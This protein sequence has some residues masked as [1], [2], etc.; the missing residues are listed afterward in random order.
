MI[1]TEKIASAKVL[2]SLYPVAGRLARD[3][4]SR[5]EINCDGEGVLFIEAETGSAM[6]DLICWF[7]AQRRT[8]TAYSYR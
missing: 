3:A 1:D 4:N 7:Q 6:G 2:E 8:S 5:I